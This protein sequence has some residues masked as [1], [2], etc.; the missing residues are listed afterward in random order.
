MGEGECARTVLP[1]Y[2]VP[3]DDEGVKVSV[4]VQYYQI[5]AFHFMKKG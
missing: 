1:D 3:F 5:T 2:G 4:L